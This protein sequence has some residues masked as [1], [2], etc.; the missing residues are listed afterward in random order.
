VNS[1]KD[2]A[3]TFNKGLKTFVGW[4]FKIPRFQQSSF[5]FMSQQYIHHCTKKQ[6]QEKPTLLTPPN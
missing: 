2:I 5:P 6:L 3:E 1:Q 4:K